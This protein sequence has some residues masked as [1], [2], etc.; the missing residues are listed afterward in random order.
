MKTQLAKSDALLLRTLYKKNVAVTRNPLMSSSYSDIHAIL[1]EKKTL[2]IPI[3]RWHSIRLDG[4]NRPLALVAATDIHANH[5]EMSSML[6]LRDHIQTAR[7]YMELSFH[8]PHAYRI[9]KKVA[10]DLILSALDLMSTPAQLD[11][12]RTVIKKGDSASQEDW[13]HIS[14]WFNDLEGKK[15]NGWRNK[16][17]SFQMLAHLAL[18]ALDRGFLSAHELLPSHKTFLSLVAPLLKSVGFPR[19][20]SSGSWEE[21]TAVRTSV[22]AVETA[23]LHKIK[24]LRPYHPFLA[25]NT[26]AFERTITAMLRD[27]LTELGKRL[28][29]ESP[30]YPKDSVKHRKADAALAYVLLYGLPQLL[31]DAQIPVAGAIRPTEAIEA[32]VL[33][34]LR[35]LDDPLTGGILRY[36]DDSYQRVN[37]HTN[38]A[39]ATV[40]GIKSFVKN[41]AGD[42]LIDLD[43]KQ[44]LRGQYM[45]AGREAAWT[46]PL[47]QIAAWAARRS[48]ERRGRNDA[49]RY[50]KIYDSYLRRMIGTVTLE[51]QWSA[52]LNADGEYEVREV[53]A[54]KLPECYI[55]YQLDDKAPLLVPSPH[56]PLNWSSVSLKEAIGLLT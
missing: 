20:E 31:A 54:W 47:G 8:S 35:T 38:A 44:S 37:F 1:R 3:I 33:A 4:Q 5:G 41:R 2:S 26:P 22:M 36:H 56:T 50:Q 30:E 51:G 42:G 29:G 28:P 9:E 45:P 11:R 23:L 17:D 10:K 12:F 53:T 55:T 21:N 46:H 19:Y 40:R 7:A 25:Q 43:L 48:M 6:Y 18:D 13:P 27:G 49:Q 16:Q 52:A 24:A 15:P 14:L 32:M 39:Q 34:S